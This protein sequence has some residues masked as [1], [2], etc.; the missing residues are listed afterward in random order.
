MTKYGMATP[1]SSSDVTSNPQPT[2]SNNNGGGSSDNTHIP[3]LPI[4]GHKL[5]EHNYLQWSQSVLMFICCKGRDD[6]LTG[7]AKSPDKENPKFKQWKV[8]NNMVMPWLI[9]SM[10]NDIGENFLLYDTAEEIWNAARDTYSNSD[11][12]SELFGIESTLHDLRQEDMSVTQ[13]S[14]S[15]TRYWQQLDM[16]EHPEWSCTKDGILYK[17]LV[18]QKR[19]FKFLLG[20]NL[21]LDEVRGRILVTKPLPNIREVFS[22]V[23]REESIKKVMMGSHVKTKSTNPTIEISALAAR[24]N[25]YN[26]NDHQ[27]RKG[28]PWCDHCRRLGHTKETCWKIHRKLAN[29]KP[30]QANNDRESRSNMVSG[31]ADSTKSNTFSKEHMDMLQRLF[32]MSPASP[33]TSVVGTDSL[34]QK[35]NFL[36][37]LN[38]KKEKSS[39]WIV[40]SGASDHMTGDISVF[41]NYRPCHGLGLGEDDWQC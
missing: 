14:N 18:E 28:R 23:R 9:N 19:I 2:T 22:E 20:L 21:N 8:E 34:A 41:K 13:Y 38:M 6:Y 27:Q 36:Q 1:S 37:A 33:T 7:V 35:G 3:H 40:D 17:E 15:L 31:T 26:F 5:N 30:N 10:N 12:T 25:L 4:T 24:P 16:F 39:S 29:W 32:N 11:N